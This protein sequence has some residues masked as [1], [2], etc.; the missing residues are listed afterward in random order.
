M[1]AVCAAGPPKWRLF[2]QRAD[3][4]VVLSHV[5]FFIERAQTSGMRNQ[6]RDVDIGLAALTKLRPEFRNTTI[7]F[8]FVFLKR[9]QQ[10]GAADSFRRRPHQDNCV[11]FPRLFSFGIAKSAVQIEDRLTVLPDRQRRAQF[12]K[13][14]EIFLEEWRDSLA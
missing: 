12:T 7:N 10:T 1:I 4:S 2:F 5:N 13:A 6:L 9:M 11:L 3:H 8:D 14:L